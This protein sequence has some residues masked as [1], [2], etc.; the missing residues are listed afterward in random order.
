MNRWQIL[1]WKSQS[2]VVLHQRFIT[3]FYETWLFTEHWNSLQAVSYTTTTMSCI[4]SATARSSHFPHLVHLGPGK[5]NRSTLLAG[6]IRS[7]PWV[8]PVSR[9]LERLISTRPEQMLKVRKEHHGFL[10]EQLVPHPPTLG[11]PQ[12]ENPKRSCNLG[13][14]WSGFTQLFPTA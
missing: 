8:H 5:E 13:L 2:Q 7:T 10:Q 9:R 1:D 4:T 11:F 3:D 6:N 12:G 14:H